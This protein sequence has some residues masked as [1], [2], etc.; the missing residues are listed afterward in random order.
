[1]KRHA[2][3]VL[4]TAALC[5]VAATGRADDTLTNLTI[6]GFLSQGFG[7]AADSSATVVGIT[8]D[9]TTD[10]RTAALQFSY[11]ITEKD[12][13]ILQLSHERIGVDPRAAFLSDVA[14]D[15][16]VYE[17][18]FPTD[19]TVRV[20]RIPIPL[21]IYNEIR[22]VGTLLPFYRPPNAFYAETNFVSETLDGVLVSQRI[23]KGKWSVDVEPWAGGWNTLAI[24]I[25]GLLRARATNVL[26]G[27]V[28]LKT[29]LSGLRVGGAAFR[30]TLRRDLVSPPPA[31]PVSGPE[32]RT[33]WQ[34]SGDG[35]FE[36]FVLRSEFSLSKDADSR[37][38]AYYAELSVPVAKFKFSAQYSKFWVSW[39]AGPNSGFVSSG[40]RDMAAGINYSFRPNIVVKLEA[41]DGEGVGI[42]VP[43][44]AENRYGLASL[45][46]SF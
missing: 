21:G 31:T 20:G 42:R 39:Y 7:R 27:T 45:A 2:G 40:G 44:P 30:S 33:L 6:H 46:V 24:N 23:G 43:K 37:D 3:R 12:R 4:A 26:G 11:A 15:W 5:L 32:K 28:W 41:H 16:A 10:Y 1:M 35:S 13:V 22:D 14:F 9:G 25:N 17:H 34:V 19:T 29:P 18:K 38:R 36:K 8:K